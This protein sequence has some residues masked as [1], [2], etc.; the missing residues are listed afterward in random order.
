MVTIF[1]AVVKCRCADTSQDNLYAKHHVLLMVS[2]RCG[3]GNCLHT[4]DGFDV[5]MGGQCV[6][7]GGVCWEYSLC[8]VQ[9]TEVRPVSCRHFSV[10]RK[11]V[12][13]SGNFID[14]P[15]ASMY[16]ISQNASALIGKHGYPLC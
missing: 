14:L 1:L 15:F 12:G 2:V 4:E 9:G 3:V 10:A 7:V 6:A 13:P 5:R 16:H 8:S 11:I